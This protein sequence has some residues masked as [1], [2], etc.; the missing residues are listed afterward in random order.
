MNMKSVLC[1]S[2]FT[3]SGLVMS[4]AAGADKDNTSL[5]KACNTDGGA[6]SHAT[7]VQEK[8]PCTNESQAEERNKREKLYWE[9][10][11]RIQRETTLNSN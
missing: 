6:T 2:L 10:V 8:K 11:R 5:Q 9:K 1:V 3:L 4:A 7:F